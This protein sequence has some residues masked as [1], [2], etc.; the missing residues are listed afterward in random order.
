MK[1]IQTAV[2][3]ETTFGA[4]GI[5]FLNGNLVHQL[6]FKPYVHCSNNQAEQFAILKFLQ[7]LEKQQDGQYNEERVAMYTD[8]KIAL[9]LLQNKIK[10]NCSGPCN[11]VILTRLLIM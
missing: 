11:I 9:N 8:S 3:L 4:A 7:K 10:Q 1:C 6:K 2:K 5:V